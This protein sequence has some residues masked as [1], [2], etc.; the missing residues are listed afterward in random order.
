MSNNKGRYLATMMYALWLG[1]LGADRFYLSQFNR[2]H[3][4]WAVWKL[5]TLGGVGIWWIGDL[6]Y[7][8]ANR[9]KFN[10]LVLSNKWSWRKFSRSIAAAST[11]FAFVCLVLTILFYSPPT[12]TLKSLT[13]FPK[14]GENGTRFDASIN[15]L[16]PYMKVQETVTSISNQQTME[17]IEYRVSWWGNLS[18]VIPTSTYSPGDYQCTIRYG[19]FRI[20]SNFTILPQ[21]VSARG[22]FANPERGSVGKNFAI[23]C[24]GLTPKGKITYIIVQLFNNSERLITKG[25]DVA[26]PNGK[27]ITSVSSEKYDPGNYAFQITDTNGT[28]SC[29]FEVMQPDISCNVY[30]KSGY[31]GTEFSITCLGLMSGLSNYEIVKMNKDTEKQVGVGTEFVKTNGKLNFKFLS[32]KCE[33]G[34]YQC[35]VKDSIRTV[36]DNFSIT[37][38]PVCSCTSP[39][40][41]CCS[42]NFTLKDSNNNDRSLKSNLGIP[43]WIAFWQSS[44]STCLDQMKIVQRIYDTCPS[45]KLVILPINVNESPGTVMKFMQAAGLNFPVL[46]DANL[47]VANVYRPQQYPG[48]YFINKNGIIKVIK[49]GPITSVEEVRA[50][51]NGMDQQ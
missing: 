41:N 18:F 35:R 1:F 47:D 45:D 2:G 7:I 20:S 30:P 3:L 29:N 8:A 39:E 21:G 14:L 19:G 15:G 34:S 16:P 43:I 17:S 9:K 44:C 10:E 28:I 48:N 49:F 37:G 50:I 26:D 23:Q 12:Q 33:P 36:N 4:K 40:R 42:P 25:E 6:V 27:L 11:V 51:V 38:L 22:C 5:A 31:V 46:F 13:I 24:N 32:D